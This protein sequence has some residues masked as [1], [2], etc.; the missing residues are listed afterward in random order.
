LSG[1]ER[2]RDRSEVRPK[3][4]V[5]ANA[6][7]SPRSAGFVAVAEALGSQ[8]GDRMRPTALALTLVAVLAGLIWPPLLPPARIRTYPPERG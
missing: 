7:G 6:I 5:V 1:T 4:V 8:A 3:R 2:R